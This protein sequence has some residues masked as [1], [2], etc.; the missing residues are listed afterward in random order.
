MSSSLHASELSSWFFCKSFYIPNVASKS[1]SF[2]FL[3]RLPD[4]NL[5]D[6]CSFLYVYPRLL[7][8]FPPPTSSLVFVFHFLL[9]LWLNRSWEEYHRCRILYSAKPPKTMDMNSHHS[10]HHVLLSLCTLTS[11]EYHSIAP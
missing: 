9:I 4:I 11:L 8:Y 5:S 10:A 7:R 3:R 1:L 6:S 2:P